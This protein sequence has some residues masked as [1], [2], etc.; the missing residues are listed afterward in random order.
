MWSVLFYFQFLEEVKKMDGLKSQVPQLM[1]IPDASEYFGISQYYL[2]K[3]V[4]SGKIPHIR[5]GNK[6]LICVDALRRILALSGCQ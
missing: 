5:T 2:R 3:G 6:Y 1:D 4:R